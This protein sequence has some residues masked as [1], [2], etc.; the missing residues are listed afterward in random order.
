MSASSV[1]HT[2][3]QAKM[4]L[5][6]VTDLV[7]TIC[8]AAAFCLVALDV[9]PAVAALLAAFRACGMEDAGEQLVPEAMHMSHISATLIELANCCK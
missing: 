8:F 4:G 9:R 3:S 6:P 1:Q 7:L 5:D 2:H